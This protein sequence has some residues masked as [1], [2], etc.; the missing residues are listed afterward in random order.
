MAVSIRV[1]GVVWIWIK[2]RCVGCEVDTV[3]IKD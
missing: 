2:T 3:Q 1:Q